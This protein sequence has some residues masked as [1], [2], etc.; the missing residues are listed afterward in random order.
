MLTPIPNATRGQNWFSIMNQ[1]F[2]RLSFP[3]LTV[4]A[5]VS[6]FSCIVQVAPLLQ[7]DGHVIEPSVLEV[8]LTPW[9]SIRD[10]EPSHFG[11][12]TLNSLLSLF[13]LYFHVPSGFQ[14]NDIRRKKHLAGLREPP[15]AIRNFA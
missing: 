3:S 13:E 14:L 9:W 15:V 4:A 8:W 1:T 12:V 6:I 11:T 10:V 2:L 7:P 5:H